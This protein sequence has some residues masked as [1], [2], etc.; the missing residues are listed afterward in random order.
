[1]SESKA[2]ELK[3][4]CTPHQETFDTLL[5]Y[6]K[7]LLLIHV[8][9]KTKNH[10]C[11]SIVIKICNKAGMPLVSYDITGWTQSLDDNL[12]NEALAQK[13]G[14]LTTELDELTIRLREVTALLQAYRL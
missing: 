10:K 1:M 3:G 4:L 14:Y 6:D 9:M 7:H 11:N 12:I 13:F 8:Y 2:R 5:C